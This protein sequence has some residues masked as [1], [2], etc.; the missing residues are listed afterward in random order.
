VT[1]RV[2]DSGRGLSNASGTGVGLANIRARLAAM[3][4]RRDLVRL[5]Q[6]ATAGVTATVTIPAATSTSALA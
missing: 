3:Y 2:V 1:L 5:E 4:G 6:N